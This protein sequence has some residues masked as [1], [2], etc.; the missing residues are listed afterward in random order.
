V[1]LPPYPS[2]TQ[3]PQQQALQQVQQYSPQ[4]HIP[5]YQQQQFN[6]PAGLQAQQ[7]QQQQQQQYPLVCPTAHPSFPPRSPRQQRPS[8]NPRQNDEVIVHVMCVNVGMLCTWY[9]M[10]CTWYCML[11]TWYC[12]RRWVGVRETVFRVA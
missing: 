12:M 3:Q 2:T 10:L 9:C 11:C 4:S 5:A 7:Q 6:P 1:Q 8:F